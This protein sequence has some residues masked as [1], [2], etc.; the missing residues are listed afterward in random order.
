M[1][2]RAA[3]LTGRL[4]IAQPIFGGP[5]AGVTTPALVAEVSN[6][7]G[8]GIWGCGMMPPAAITQAVADTRKLTGR[9]FGL[10]LFITPQPVVD[11]AQ[12][13]RMRAK[14]A[15]YYAE[16]GVALPPVP[17]SVAPD[18]A[19]QFETALEAKLPV[20]SFTFGLLDRAQVDALH[21]RGAFVIGTASCVAEARAIAALGCDAVV[22]QGAET[23]GHRGSFA[24]P[25]EQAQ[26]GLF[27]L[28]P[29]IAAAV[30]IPVIAAGAVMTGAQIGAALLL[31]ASG[32]QLG[33]ALL[34]TPECGTSAGYKAALGQAT[35]IDT[36]VTRAFSGR[37]ARGL[38]NRFMDEVGEAD[39]P[40][41]PIQN[42]LTGPLR[43]AANAQ[44]R[45]EFVSL[46][47]GQGAA[48]ARAEPVAAVLR[49]LIEEFESLP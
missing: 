14:L 4:G 5:M 48:L 44:G 25:F 8:L 27:A 21:A 39:V 47:A 37:P 7:G 9:P 45:A 6:A 46:W 36:Q 23:G 29:Q 43:A 2:E 32:V 40:E 12:V 1:R 35:D 24:V 26:V 17:A 42:A 31:G 49:R 33:S 18:F 34:R 22:A 11:A 10:N 30:E 28:L 3:R 16:L 15:P 19:A 13:E 20:F 41:Y 38:R